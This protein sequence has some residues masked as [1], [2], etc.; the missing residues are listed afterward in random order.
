MRNNGKEDETKVFYSDEE[1][2]RFLREEEARKRQSKKRKAVRKLLSKKRKAARK[3][4]SKKWYICANYFFIT[5]DILI[6][7]MLLGVSIG[8]GLIPLIGTLFW[9]WCLLFVGALIFYGSANWIYNFYN[10]KELA[11]N[12]L[13]AG[14]LLILMA[15][16]VAHVVAPVV[17]VVGSFVG[18]FCCNN[19]KLFLELR[20]VYLQYT[21]VESGR[22]FQF[23]KLNL[24]GRLTCILSCTGFSVVTGFVVAGIISPVLIGIASG[25]FLLV[26]LLSL[27][28]TSAIFTNAKR[29]NQDDEL[30][31][32]YE[33]GEKYES[34]IEISSS[35][36]AFLNLDQQTVNQ[37]EQEEDAHEEI[38]P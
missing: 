13:I 26:E 7:S 23:L 5:S 18:L 4:L 16:V 8:F 1:L 20:V 33:K 10:K 30:N 11:F 14:T 27:I 34:V 21:D 31:I 9:A 38:S 32:K 24:L 12:Y 28:E 2:T 25:Y 37:L 19:V 36:S 17:G 35:N 3:L 6:D 15:L 29:R 22:R